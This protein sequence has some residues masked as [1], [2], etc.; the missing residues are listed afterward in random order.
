MWIQYNHGTNHRLCEVRQVLPKSPHARVFESILEFASYMQEF[1][2]DINNQIH[3]SNIIYKTR[4]GSRQQR[5]N[6]NL[7]DY[8]MIQIRPK[9]YPLG[10][11]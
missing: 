3:A 2:I 6:F 11:V 4:F 10:T 9:R 1:H 5:L 8:I 7:G